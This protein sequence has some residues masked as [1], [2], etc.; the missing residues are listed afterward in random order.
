MSSV[1]GPAD[2]SS[3]HSFHPERHRGTWFYGAGVL[4]SAAGI[5]TGMVFLFSAV[6]IVF[7]AFLFLAVLSFILLPIFANALISLYRAKYIVDR[8][9]LLLQWGGRVERIPVGQI[10]WVRT[11]DSLGLEM[12]VPRFYR[13][14][15]VRGTVQTRELGK[16]EFLSDTVEQSIFI[17][18]PNCVYVISPTDMAG[19]LTEIRDAMESGS[20]AKTEAVSLE[21]ETVLKGIWQRPVGR[22]LLV[23]LLMCNLALLVIVEMMLSR[24]N[25]LLLFQQQTVITLTSLRLMPFLSTFFGLIDFTLGMLFFQRLKHVEVSYV[26]WASGSL[27]PILFSISIGLS[28]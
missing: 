22:L 6:G 3:S 21:K 20:L 19:F 14:G 4:L 1:Y 5:V 7:V 23:S 17:A 15:I 24:E 18:A 16:V 28:L 13:F 11:F 12:H 8:E 25:S 26:L 10:E 9:S 27:V 2:H